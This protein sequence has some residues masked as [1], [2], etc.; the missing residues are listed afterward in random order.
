MSRRAIL[1]LATLLLA[2]AFAAA[3]CNGGGDD[4]D[5]D[6]TSEATATELTEAD[7][8]SIL[9][10]ILLQLSDLPAG[11]TVM[12]DDTQDNASAIQANPD[13]AA[14]FEEC[15]RLL[16]RTT[17]YQPEDLI[18]SF[19]GGET[20]SFFSTATVYATEDG[21]ARCAQRTAERLAEPGGLARQFGGLFINPE[22]VV[23]EGVEWPAVGEAS[24]AATLTGQ[25]EAAGTTIDLTILVVGFRDGNLTGAVGS[26]RSGSTPPNDELAPYVDLVV[27]RIA[28]ER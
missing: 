15:R 3:A 22:A 4:G 6:A 26:A 12:S 11:W 25:I 18:N 8:T 21:A 23:V 9:E 16:S 20:L 17:T 10:R 27:A 24:F 13:D 2:L 28:D 14:L 7:A 5:A 1:A 19:L